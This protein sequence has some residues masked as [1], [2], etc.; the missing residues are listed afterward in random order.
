MALTFTKVPD[1]EDVW[2]KHR[3]T[4]FDIA[5]DTS[6]P[7][8][9][10]AITPAN[11]GLRIIRMA[12]VGGNGGVG[13]AASLLFSW[14]NVNNKLRAFYPSGGGAAAPGAIGAPAIASGSTSVT[15]A[16]A[17][18]NTDLV[19][20]QG[21]EVGNTTDLSSITALRVIFIGEE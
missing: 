16:A 14:D 10:Y 1:A 12:F 19:P 5:L 21:A 18:G 9:G 17:N 4:M 6:Y 3:V 7:T 13:N 15:S 2:G 11:V 8:N 20:G